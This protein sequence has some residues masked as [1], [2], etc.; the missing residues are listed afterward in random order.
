MEELTIDY[1]NLELK[2]ILIELELATFP[3][4]KK[5]TYIKKPN[6]ATSVGYDKKCW[7]SRKQYHKARQRYQLHRS[8]VNFNDTIEKSREYKGN[9]KRVKNI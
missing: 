1:S 7:T 2:Q 4:H 9:L 3:P 5:R 6:N 8:N